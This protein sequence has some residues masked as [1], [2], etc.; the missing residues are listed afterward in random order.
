MKIGL[1]IGNFVSGIILTVFYFTAFALF[2]IP[3]KLFGKNPFAA[4]SKNSN[5]IAKKNT[6][7]TLKE[8]ETEF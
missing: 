7:A 1:I 4:Q 5:W 8:F 2:A 6:I 3:I